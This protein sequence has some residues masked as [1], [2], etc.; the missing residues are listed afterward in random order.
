MNEEQKP[1]YIEKQT[2]FKLWLDSVAYASNDERVEELRSETDYPAETTTVRDALYTKY[3]MKYANDGDHYSLE[4]KAFDLYKELYPEHVIY[5]IQYLHSP[6][7]RLQGKTTQTLKFIGSGAIK[8]TDDQVS[9]PES[10]DHSEVMK[11]LVNVKTEQNLSDLISSA[12][13]CETWQKVGVDELFA[14]LDNTTTQG[15][16]EGSS[17]ESKKKKVL[18]LLADGALTFPVDATLTLESAVIKNIT[19]T[20]EL[21]EFIASADFP[22][23]EKHEVA[24]EKLFDFVYPERKR[25]TPE[26]AKA[27]VEKLAN[28]EDGGIDILV[29]NVEKGC[30]KEYIVAALPSETMEILFEG[31][32]GVKRKDTYYDNE[33]TGLRNID[34]RHEL[35]RPINAL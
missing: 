16:E 19:T 7:L 12:T 17:L 28:E 4:N 34:K 3:N 18:S 20:S 11:L 31:A 25:F 8:L 6:E 14:S 27:L 24:R 1:V 35:N 30:P 13:I 9:T 22:S 2:N 33:K 23:G 32:L 10:P 21:L 26:Y 5:P 29:E 15:L